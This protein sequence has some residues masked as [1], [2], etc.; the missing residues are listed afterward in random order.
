MSGADDNGFDARDLRRAFGNFATGV[1]IVTTLDSDAKPCG[2]TANSF[3]S[4]S[5]EPPLLLV[6]IASSAHGCEIFRGSS[7]FAVNILAQSQRDLSN[8]FARAGAD[9]FAGVEWRAAV[10]GAPILDGVVAWFDC[11]H[12]EQVEAGD[13]V[14]LIGRVQDY[15]HATQAPLG[16]CR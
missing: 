4:V 11:A 12:F 13:H 6:S 1:T 5:I 8:R 14:L 3:T 7:G 2:F 16:F 10:T 9:K 15:A